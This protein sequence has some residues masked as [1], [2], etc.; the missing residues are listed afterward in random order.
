MVF[1]QNCGLRKIATASVLILKQ[2]KVNPCSFVL[3]KN[4]NGILYYFCRL[5]NWNGAKNEY[6]HEQRRYNIKSMVRT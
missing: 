6:G 4:H 5:M 2:Y 3:V 1:R